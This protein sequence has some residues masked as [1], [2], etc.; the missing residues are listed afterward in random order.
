[1]ICRVAQ[2]SV[3]PPSLPILPARRRGPAEY[4]QSL[5]REEERPGRRRADALATLASARA[6][7]AEPNRDNLAA[8]RACQ[9]G[10]GPF[11]QRAAQNLLTAKLLTESCA[12]IAEWA[13]W[14]SEQVEHWP[15][16][17]RHVEPDQKAMA[18]AVQRARSSETAS[19]T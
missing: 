13:D 9:A 16:D 19:A 5:R 2:S 8:G 11:Q 7:A 10:A 12:M 15:D 14:A 3:V 18:A 4:P 17:I 1:L 6:W